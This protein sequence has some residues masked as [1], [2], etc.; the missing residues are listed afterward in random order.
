MSTLTTFTPKLHH[1]WSTLSQ[2]PVAVKELRSRMRGRRTFV[3]LTCYLA[4]LVAL[5]GLVYHSIYASRPAV[6]GPPSALAGKAILATVVTFQGFV[7]VF[8]SMSFTN[9]AIIGEKERQTYDLLLATALPAEQLVLGKLLSALIY[10]LLLVFACIPLASIAFI[11]GGVAL[12][13][14]VISQLLLLFS[15]VTFALIGLYASSLARTIQTANVASFSA[16]SFLLVG[17]PTLAYLSSNAFMFIWSRLPGFVQAYLA[18]IIVCTNLPATLIA[19]DSFLI[20]E[21]TIWAFKV[22]D[23][24]DY[25]IISPW[26][27][28]LLFNILLSLILYKLAVRQIKQIP[29]L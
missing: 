17:L 21:G 29:E 26:I 6:F 1:V 13:E 23:S 11:L 18:L 22:A 24:P 2:N 3:Y 15:A 5:V 16:A 8:G 19:T 25:W 20:S 14:I 12:S 9:S 7:V 4:F 28:H 10:V 27:I